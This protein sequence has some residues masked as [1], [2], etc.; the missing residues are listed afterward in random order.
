MLYQTMFAP[1]GEVVGIKAD[2]YKAAR[3]NKVIDLCYHFPIRF[4]DRENSPPLDSV[5]SDEVISTIV[6][7]LDGPNLYN[8]RIKKILC[9]N[10]TGYITIIYFRQIPRF[11]LPLFREGMEIGIS[12][13]VDRRG[14]TLSMAHPDFVVHRNEY[15]KIAKAE[16]RYPSIK[17]VSNKHVEASIITAINRLK[18]SFSPEEWIP[19]KIIERHGWPAWKEA[20]LN[21][22]SNVDREIHRLSKERLAFDELYAHQLML[23]DYRRKNKIQIR[24]PGDVETSELEQELLKLLPFEL[25]SDQQQVLR[26]IKSDR[27]SGYKMLR[28]L[29]GDVGSGKT[30]VGVFATLIA[31]KEDRGQAAFMAPTELLA[32]QHFNVIKKYLD[33]LSISSALLTSNVRGVERRGILRSIAEGET[34]VVVGTHA[35]FQDAVS[36]NSLQLIIIDEQ[37]K[38]GV[39]QRQRLSEQ[40]PDAD[41]LMMSA[42]P[43]PRSLSM[44]QF[45]DLDI[46]IIRE[47]PKGRLPIQTLVQSINNLDSL[48]AKLDNI[49]AKGESIYWLCP[50]I[51][52]SEKLDLMNVHHRYEHLNSIF[53]GK[54]A[55]IHSKV[56]EEEQSSIISEFKEGKKQLL[57]ATTVIEIGLDIPRATVIVI[58]N[59]ESFGLSQLHQLRGRVG[60][61]DKQSFCILLHKPPLTNVAK[62]RLNAMKGLN[63]GFKIAEE[64]LKIR[65]AGDIIGLKQSGIPDFRLFNFIEHS[66]IVGEAYAAARDVS[67]IPRGL[68]EVFYYKSVVERAV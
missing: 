6:T 13:K 24:P 58:E 22:H 21:M 38:F 60:R 39:L 68:T 46:S 10:N 41:I 35:I 31:L 66:H 11:L 4:I 27:A 37:H 40:S 56:A 12:G 15:D 59:A 23:A 1:V 17:G 7:V 16:R 9:K 18:V 42:T 2:L 61:N 49:M 65:G 54:I 36:F 45:G 44:V 25:T 51:E 53:P 55:I 57:L 20:M 62:H 64:D 19:A 8:K 29:Q 50:L 47:K 26:D 63:D 30:I 28:M 34:Q 67:E 48:V 3:I 32:K 5:I 52:E 14:G 33:P 43:I